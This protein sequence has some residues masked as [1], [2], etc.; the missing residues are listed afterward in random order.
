VLLSASSA[1][2]THATRIELEYSLLRVIGFVVTVTSAPTVE[3]GA[4][5][6]GW[7]MGKIVLLLLLLTRLTRLLLTRLLDPWKV[8]GSTTAWATTRLLVLVLPDQTVLSE[9]AGVSR[10]CSG[11]AV[12]TMGSWLFTDCQTA[13]LLC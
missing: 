7:R 13:T 1:V 2:P 4:P 8:Q 10:A 3:K 12:P 5:G 6:R 11:G 9:N